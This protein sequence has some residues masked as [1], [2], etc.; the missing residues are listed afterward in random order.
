MFQNLV[1]CRIQLEL[2]L[3]FGK[4]Q[5]QSSQRE[6]LRFISLGM[7]VHV[8][9]CVCLLSVC[10]D[11]VSVKLV[12]IFHKCYSCHSKELQSTFHQSHGN[13]FESWVCFFFSVCVMLYS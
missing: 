8:R 3:Q 5:H 9:V 10:L 4:P 7:F 11:T 1:V 13:F 2:A 12:L 6:C